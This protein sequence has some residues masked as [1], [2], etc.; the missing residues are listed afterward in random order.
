MALAVM[1]S[2]G[3]TAVELFM[4]PYWILEKGYNRRLGDRADAAWSQ[5]V[6]LWVQAIRIDS[7]VATGLAT[8]MT[9]AFFLLGSALF[10]D[11]E[12]AAFLSPPTLLA[13]FS[14][15]LVFNS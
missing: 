8:L 6:R 13:A 14:L 10:S 7:G 9:A 4:Y 5:R 12:P 11:S 2:V 15:W 1:G 3:A